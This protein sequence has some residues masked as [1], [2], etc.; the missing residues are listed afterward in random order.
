ML[1]LKK[2]AYTIFMAS[3]TILVG[4]FLWAGISGTRLLGDGKGTYEPG[5]KT[6]QRMGTSSGTYH[7]FYHK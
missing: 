3:L 1:K 5:E 2:S 4:I 7:R 6:A